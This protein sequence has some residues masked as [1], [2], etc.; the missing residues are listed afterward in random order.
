MSFLAARLRASLTPRI[1]E[2]PVAAAASF[3][4]GA[5]LV[6]DANGAWAEAGADPAAIGAFAESAYE[7]DATGFVRTGRT[8]FPPGYMQ[9]CLA[10]GQ[11][12]QAEYVGA[13]PAAAGGSY[14][15]TRGADGIWRVDFAKVAASARLKLE[16]IDWTAA[17]LNKNRVLVSVLAANVQ[18]IG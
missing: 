12:F 8:E 10:E 4:R 6:M 3:K 5:A 18:A 17:P 14:G 7:A 9:G 2:K 11:V 15:L 13:L 16:S 1:R